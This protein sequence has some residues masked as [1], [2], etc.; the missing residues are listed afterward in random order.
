MAGVVRGAS[1]PKEASTAPATLGTGWTQIDA[2]V[3]VNILYAFGTGMYFIFA[4]I[5]FV[6]INECSLN[7]DQCAQNCQNTQ[8]SYT[9][10]CNS[11]YTLSSN[12]RSCNGQ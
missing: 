5:G 1:I 11:G 8:G 7:T 2:V 9:C 6:D 4:G 3:Q 10:S 12:G